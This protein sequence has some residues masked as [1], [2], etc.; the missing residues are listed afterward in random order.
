MRAFER[1]RELDAEA[2]P[3]T[4]FGLG[5][6]ASLATDRPKRGEHRAHVAVQTVSRT[7]VVSLVFEKGRRT[8]A[9]EEAVVTHAIVAAL[10]DAAGVHSLD[11]SRTPPGME[12][13]IVDAVAPP[14]WRELL[15]GSRKAVA[16]NDAPEP[17][18]GA[19]CLVPGSFNPLHA[20]HA[21]LAAFAARRTGRPAVFELSI[22]N[23]DKPPLDFVDLRRRVEGLVGKPLW[24]TCAPTFI[25]KARLAPGAVFAVGADTIERIG[26]DRYY[27]NTEARGAAIDELAT[28]GC[29]LLVFG[30]QRGEWFQTLK[31]L[32]L[33]PTLRAMCDGVSE[34]E[35]RVDVSSTD[36]RE[37]PNRIVGG[38]S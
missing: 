37:C 14:E 30:R 10:A 18:S 32:T 15:A 3:A 29:R 38:V 34:A 31:D 6:T 27:A 21:E 22:A 13:T 25:E 33:P 19:V 12:A 28:L 11:L 7:L 26:E 24:L 2:T 8:R 9:E 23:V 36:L 5:A 4:C 35:F 20:G 16:L 17:G 1:A